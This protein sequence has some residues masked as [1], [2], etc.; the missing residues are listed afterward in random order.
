MK[1]FRHITK[2][3][4]FAADQNNKAEGLMSA[5]TSLACVADG[6]FPV[7]AVVTVCDAGYN[8]LRSVSIHLRMPRTKTNLVKR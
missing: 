8:E 1:H 4:N 3:S 2:H 6:N 7:K 5:S